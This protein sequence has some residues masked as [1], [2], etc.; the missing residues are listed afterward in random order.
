MVKRGSTYLRW[1]LLLAGRLV[2]KYDMTFAEVLARKL[3][4]GKHYNVAVS[5]VAKKLIRVIYHLMVSGEPYI[6]QQ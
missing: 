6:T 5:H 2:S 1:A 4:E 3:A